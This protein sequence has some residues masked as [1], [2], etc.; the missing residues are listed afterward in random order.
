MF[1]KVFKILLILSLL[2]SPAF[3]VGGEDS[4]FSQSSEN[5]IIQTRFF[6]AGGR[7]STSENYSNLH[8]VGGS[9]LGRSNSDLYANDAGFVGEVSGS[10]TST[11]PSIESVAFD[12]REVVDND[13]IAADAEMTATI[14][15]LGGGVSVEASKVVVGNTTTYFS[16]LTSPSTYDASTGSLTFQHDLAVGAH[17]IQIVA[18]NTSNDSSAYSRS[19]K[20]ETGDVSAAQALIYPNPY[21]PSQGNARI[22]Y[23]LNKDANVTIYIFNEINQLVWRRNYNSGTNGGRVGYNE[24]TWDGQ[25][26]FGQTAA[27]GA[28]FLRIAAEGKVVGRIKIAV[29]R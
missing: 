2:V 19:L 25:T 6:G 8:S 3:T 15:N 1:N 18:F 5:Y 27:N 10:E 14:V 22:G 23:Q 4:G 26:D 11:P 21:N 16:D 13:Y 24:I 17:T 9:P 12:S 28:Y 20:V 29:L 7:T